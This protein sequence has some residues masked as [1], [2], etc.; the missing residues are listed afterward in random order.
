MIYN[1]VPCDH[2]IL[3]TEMK[4]FDFENPPVNPIELSNNL[5]ETMAHHK[6]LGL[7]ANQCGLPYRVFALWSELPL[8]C[9]NPRVID[10]TT[11]QVTLD[12]GCLSFPHLTL[13]IKRPKVI[14]VRFQDHTGEI[15]TDKFIGMTAR[16]YLHEL[17]HLNGIDYTQKANPFHLARGLRKQ[18][19]ILRKLKGATHEYA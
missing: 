16:C 12:E 11:E 8:V 7:S 17:D 6:G 1:L 5:I 13:P 14:K 19:I 18:K 15:R 4:K 10:E 9:F 2:P 3:R